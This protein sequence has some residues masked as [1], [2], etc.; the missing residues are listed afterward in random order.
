MLFKGTSVK[1]IGVFI[2]FGGNSGWACE[3]GSTP[4]YAHSL[5]D[6]NR[7]CAYLTNLSRDDISQIHDQRSMD[8]KP[9]NYLGISLSSISHELSLDKLPVISA[10]ERLAQVFQAFILFG[11]HHSGIT[12]IFRN[13]YESELVSKYRFKHSPIDLNGLNGEILGVL[14]FK[15]SGHE[16]YFS[17]PVSMYH[18]RFDYFESI[19]NMSIPR[20]QMSRVS[21]KYLD[22]DKKSFIRYA[23][24]S[25]NEM[26][27]K[28]VINNQHGP[29]SKI[30]DY[31]ES[32]WLT[33][34]EFFFLD[35][36][37]A[38]DVQD[39]YM[40]GS[41]TNLDLGDVDMGKYSRIAYSYG[42][43]LRS[44]WSSF[45][46]VHD[47]D[48]CINPAKVWV[49]SYDRIQCIKLALAV[50]EEYGDHQLI[51]LGYGKIT[52][53]QGE[54]DY[55]SIARFCGLMNMVPNL[56]PGI[57][58][59]NDSGP[60]DEASSTVLREA[61]KRGALD[62]ILQLNELAKEEI[63][64]FYEELKLEQDMKLSARYR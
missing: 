51:E 53:C 56:N 2:D 12:S 20:G 33:K 6:L 25:I 13:Y 44:L 21:E 9:D 43:Y 22:G 10:C 60:V 52:F 34:Q 38:M 16:N 42:L 63:R 23:D 45:M 46:H 41:K 36:Y 4:Y 15:A 28:V 30:I 39:A 24:Q 1:K 61:N 40:F 62:F 32:C 3:A 5:G 27:V 18:N 8:L 59:D 58:L 14:P 57:K 47:E 29:L 54:A 26:L 37:L 35:E 49:S 48:G 64:V 50:Q 7:E 19:S 31:P 55:P 11:K 17:T